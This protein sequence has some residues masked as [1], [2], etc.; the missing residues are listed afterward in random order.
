MKQRD[1]ALKFV[2]GDRIRSKKKKMSDNQTS[3][4]QNNTEAALDAKAENEI[5]KTGLFIS[6]G[7]ERFALSKDG[8]SLNSRQASYRQFLKENYKEQLEIE[9]AEREI[10]KLNL[11]SMIIG[12]GDYFR[13]YEIDK[14]FSFKEGKDE[15]GTLLHHHVDYENLNKSNSWWQQGAHTDFSLGVK[16]NF[17][18]QVKF[19]ATLTFNR[20]EDFLPGTIAFAE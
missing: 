4:V 18:D 9:K 6:V 8:A 12:D 14:F 19:D 13:I 7:N 15:M 17:L 16:S 5:I 11:E 2:V 10:E 20:F 3:A 1:G